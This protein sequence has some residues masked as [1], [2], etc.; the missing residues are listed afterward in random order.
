MTHPLENNKLKITEIKLSNPHTLVPLNTEVEA[1]IEINLQNGQYAW[2]I[3]LED[4]LIKKKPYSS[5]LRTVTIKLDKPGKY[6]LKGYA[7]DTKGNTTSLYARSISVYS[8]RGYKKSKSSIKDIYPSINVPYERLDKI[9]F[10]STNATMY[11]IN[12]NN[13]TYD[14]LVKRDLNDPN[15]TVMGSGAYDSDKGDLPVFQRHSWMHKIDGN[16]IYYNDPTLYLDKINIG[17]GQGTEEEFYLQNISEILKSIAE[18]IG[19]NHK[20]ILFYGSSAGGFMSLVLGGY[21]KG[22][23]VLVN[24]PQTIVPNY[25]EQHVNAMCSVSYNV[26][27]YKKVNDKFKNRLDI[28]AFYKDINYV[29]N[30]Y[31]M[32]N[33][34]CEHDME[35]HYI[36]FNLFYY[37]M[38]KSLKFNNLVSYLYWDNEAQH[39]P[40][41]KKRTLDFINK[42]KEMWL[43]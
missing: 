6:K 16:V 29:P 11:S 31:Y 13:Q 2:Y 14:F 4:V 24:N 33:S 19:I 1:K 3:Y 43:D 20:N 7:K 5:N 22:S 38:R 40:L 23:S 28:R 10:D 41:D 25:Y 37:E 17:W 18:N 39:N 15:L 30:I 36:P 27:D 34:A 9:E 32:Q 12:Y 21:V 26:F 8:Q 42:V 35:N